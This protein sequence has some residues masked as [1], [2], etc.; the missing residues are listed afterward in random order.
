MV[1]M[2]A[3]NLIVINETLLVLVLLKVIEFSLIRIKQ[4]AL[5]QV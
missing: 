2:F 1:Q 3:L 4:T 5:C